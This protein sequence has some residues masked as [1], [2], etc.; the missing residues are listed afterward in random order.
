[1]FNVTGKGLVC[2]E[3]ELRYTK[4]GTALVK[5]TLVNNEEYKGETTGH[6]TNVILWGNRAIEFAERVRKGCIIE[7]TNGILKHPTYKKKDG[8]TVYSTEVTILEWKPIRNLNKENKNNN[9]QNKDYRTTSE[10][11]P[12]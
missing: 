4:G 3:V 10:D 7:I 6:F 11:I 8:Q 9:Q 12:F 2:K 5:T 1:M